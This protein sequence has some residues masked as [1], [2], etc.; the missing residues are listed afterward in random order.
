L[1]RRYGNC[2][3]NAKADADPHL[4]TPAIFL[5]AGMNPTLDRLAIGSAQNRPF[6][7]P[8]QL[9]TFQNRRN[10]I[11]NWS[12]FQI[13]PCLQFNGLTPSVVAVVFPQARVENPIPA[14]ASVPKLLD[15]S[16]VMIWQAGFDYPI[17]AFV[18]PLLD[19]YGVPKVAVVVFESQHALAS[20]HEY[21][22]S[23]ICF[24]RP[25]AMN[26]AGRAAVGAAVFR[27][28]EV[29]PGAV[30]RI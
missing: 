28:P 5:L 16:K 24:G 1:V 8:A 20:P 19:Y 6:D 7:Q 9:S 13:G 29:H 17:T 11:G 22:L 2:A 14:D 18:F 4:W 10:L 12:R 23:Q 21:I 30:E 27:P 25:Q 26:L 3:E 15:N